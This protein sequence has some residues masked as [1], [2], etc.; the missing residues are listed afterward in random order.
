MTGRERITAILNDR[1]ADR[2]GFWLG[3]PADETKKTYCDYFGIT[4]SLADFSES[5]NKGKTTLLTT[6]FGLMDVELALK[7]ES[8]FLWFS[9]ELD[10]SCWR[11]PQGTPMFDVTGG[12]KLENMSQTGVFADC[13]DIREVEGFDWPRPDYLDFSTTHELVD[14]SISKG[15]AVFGGMWMSFFHVLCDFFGME[16]YFM[17]M[18][19][20]PEIVE[21]VTDKVLEFYLEANRRCLDVMSPKLD[22]IFFG[23]DLGSQTNLLIS[24]DM[25]E[26][27]I[28]P[29]YKKIVA[30][31]KSYKLK[32]VHHCCGAISDLIPTFIDIGIDA[33]HPIQAK[34]KGMDAEKLA[35]EF[36]KDLIFI[37]GV[38]TQQLLPFGTPEQVKAE[39]RRLKKVF[40]ERYIV[41][42]SHE[43]LLPNVSVENVIAMRDAT[44]E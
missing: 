24:P 30:Q 19:T 22:A 28:L 4:D 9:P 7:L 8:D 3:N 37:G 10:P 42:P 5:E 21:A 38:D 16:N 40:G 31:A 27:F 15:K 23:N 17:K 34:A 35:R 36:G 41:S 11:H 6:K 25:F 2:A 43:A 32:V 14:L 29:G 1:P 44:I 12:R 20:N 18:Y 39:V 26:K 13:E 33:L